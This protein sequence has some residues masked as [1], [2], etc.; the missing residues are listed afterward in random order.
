MG[1]LMS[2][3]AFLDRQDACFRDAADAL[4]R[5]HS[6]MLA[7]REPN[8]DVVTALDILSSRN[9]DRLPS[10]IKKSTI[11]PP[12][13]TKLEI[14]QTLSNLENQIRMRLLSKDVVPLPFRK[15]MTIERGC[16]TF[17]VENKFQVTLSLDTADPAAPWI[18]IDLKLLLNFVKQDYE[19]VIGINDYQLQSIL[20]SAAQSLLPP[21]AVA[22]AAPPSDSNAMAISPPPSTVSSTPPKPPLMALHDHLSNFTLRLQLEILRTQITHLARSRWVNLIA[23]EFTPAAG[24]L[25]VQ[26]WRGTNGGAVDGAIQAHFIELKIESGVGVK[27]VAASDDGTSDVVSSNTRTGAM[28]TFTPAHISVRA[29]SVM[30]TPGVESPGPETAF[31][32]PETNAPLELRLDTELL[33]IETLVTLV[34]RKQAVELARH[35]S[36]VFEK[37]FL[38]VVLDL[39]D[40]EANAAPGVTVFYRGEKGVRVAID[41]RSGRMRVSQVGGV[42]TEASLDAASVE[43]WT[44]VQ[45]AVHRDWMAAVAIIRDLR[46]ATYLEDVQR[47][48]VLLKDETV[49]YLAEMPFEEELVAQVMRQRE[50]VRVGVVRFMEWVDCYL[51]VAVGD[52]EELRGV[53]GGKKEE[54][55]PFYR[56]WVVLTSDGSASNSTV[57]KT[58][59]P[60][61]HANV[62]D[63]LHL[64]STNTTPPP[65]T[66]SKRRKRAPPKSPTTPRVPMELQTAG[67]GHPVL[68]SAMGTPVL[69]AIL[70]YARKQFAFLTMLSQVDDMALD[71]DLCF[72]QSHAATPPRIDQ[73]ALISPKI[74]IHPFFFDIARTIQGKSGLHL[75]PA[76]TVEDK[77]MKYCFGNLYVCLEGGRVVG[78]VRLTM[79][80]L[81]AVG[82][83]EMDCSSASYDPATC[84][85]TLTTPPGGSA[86]QILHDWK[87]LAAVAEV[88][89]QIQARQKWF[90]KHGVQI[91]GYAVGTL[92]M[93]VEGFGL[94]GSVGGG[95]GSLVMRLR[96]KRFVER[97]VVD[98]KMGAGLDQFVLEAMREDGVSVA[99]G[100]GERDR[101]VGM[102]EGVLNECLDFVIFA[103]RM[104]SIS[105]IM[106][107]LKRIEAEINIPENCV[108]GV[109]VVIVIPKSLSWIRFMNGSC[110]LDLYLFSNDMIA[111]YDAAFGSADGSPVD[112][113]LA[114][115]P[116]LT[117]HQPHSFLQLLP[118]FL[119]SHRCSSETRL[120]PLPHGVLFSS[121]VQDLILP[122]IARHMDFRSQIQW[123][124]HQTAGTLNPESL[125]ESLRIKLFKK[126]SGLAFGWIVGAELGWQLNFKRVSHQSGGVDVNVEALAGFLK[127]KF[128]ELPSE[129]YPEFAKPYQANTH[130][131]VPEWC[132][133]MPSNP[134]CQLAHLPAPGM[135]AFFVD[136]AMGRISCVFKL[137]GGPV[138]KTRFLPLRYNYK[139]KVINIWKADPNPHD[140]TYLETASPSLITTLKDLAKDAELSTLD[141]TL[142]RASSSPNNQKEKLHPSVGF[143]CQKYELYA[144]ELSE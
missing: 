110:A 124:A 35:M 106:K 69:T 104:Y 19:G 98:A 39:G 132:A 80:I 29:F 2:V 14:E 96:W 125:L 111:M 78:K 20:T 57:L 120:K 33:D 45:D 143:V 118:E 89:S 121:N 64:D 21:G 103:K 41:P 71:Y 51:V 127:A 1:E 53:L 37:E 138:G 90:S 9:F 58:C 10:I 15:N 73:L 8:Y 74:I 105:S 83:V 38:N 136:P 44:K 76:A 59:I 5:V 31:L 112:P 54:G 77:A 99:E 55:G 62:V 142:L 122:H 91:V 72:P 113:I 42:E 56:A 68:W 4:V 82:V 26:Y 65:E 60:V 27:G 95:D 94:L 50:K 49:V 85:L 107:I 63:C 79:D 18:L 129:M 3:I 84:I 40:R 88:A 101:W 137:A 144:N 23:F 139:T 116:F 92:T 134:P 141:K 48:M 36:S 25:K 6:E 13:P 117:H 119:K 17:R 75:D 43:K 114:P 11:P 61:K 24:S 52:F 140:L 126:E 81:P 131:I 86:K 34:A 7:E 22:D 46:L 12:P 109:P 130:G 47:Q 32:D 115:I 135:S 102:L 16:V 100:E 128:L 30:H 87:G 66:G 28:D 70:G 97:E 93:R 67:A 123:L 133:V 108:N